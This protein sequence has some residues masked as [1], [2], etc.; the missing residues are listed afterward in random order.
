MFYILET[1]LN[2]IWKGLTAF[3]ILWVLFVNGMLIIKRQD[4]IP[5]KYH[6]F[7]KVI[8]GLSF[9]WDVLV[10]ITVGAAVFG[11]E[12]AWDFKG[13]HA[14]YLPTLTET[15]RFTLRTYAK[16]HW[17]YKLADFICVWLVEPYDEGHCS[18]EEA[19]KTYRQNFKM[20]V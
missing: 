14:R 11:K 10:N 12:K 8:I 5:E 16:D 2:L 6:N 20:F 18:I 19:E 1:A 15:L 13:A 9:L 7:F 3:F 17:R 4:E